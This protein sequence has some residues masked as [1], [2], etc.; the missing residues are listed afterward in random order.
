ME[1]YNRNYPPL[2]GSATCYGSSCWEPF[3][4]TTGALARTASARERARTA[5]AQAL[6]ASLDRDT[7]QSVWELAAV[8]RAMLATRAA[9]DDADA[10]NKPIG[11]GDI[12]EVEVLVRICGCLK[13]KDLG[14][15]A[16]VSGSFGRTIGWQ[17]SVV[18][19]GATELDYEEWLEVMTRVA[20]ERLGHTVEKEG[21]KEDA[22]LFEHMMELFINGQIATMIPQIRNSKGM[23]T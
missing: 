1:D 9:V 15:L 13:P 7:A 19:G 6:A 16:C 20:W 21:E 22:H 18:D 11:L 14:R 17:C 4:G 23:T 10:A 12:E 3:H 5:A 8:R 2:G